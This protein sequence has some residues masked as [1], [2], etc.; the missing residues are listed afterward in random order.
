MCVDMK[1]EREID[2]IMRWIWGGIFGEVRKGLSFSF[3]VR[4]LARIH[5]KFF[6]DLLNSTF[7]IKNG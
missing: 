4:I 1:R 2:Y 6:P 5:Q 3:G 7:K